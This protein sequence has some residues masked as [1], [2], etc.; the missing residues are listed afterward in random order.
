MRG[1]HI[2][3]SSLRGD[4]VSPFSGTLESTIMQLPAGIVKI[5]KTLKYE[6]KRKRKKEKKRKI[7]GDT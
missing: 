1:S 3:L 2:S 7:F 4:V 5:W 6:K